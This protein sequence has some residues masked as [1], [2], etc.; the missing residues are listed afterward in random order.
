MS[1]NS[2]YSAKKLLRALIGAGMAGTSL[3]QLALPVLAQNET[4]AGT[5]I[6]NRATATYEDDG[7][8]N[9]NTN[10]NTVTITIAEVAGITV[11]PVGVNDLNGGSVL[12]GDTLHF[13][14]KVTN[15]GNDPTGF[16][17]PV[18]DNINIV[19]ANFVGTNPVTV[20]SQTIGG[21]TSAPNVSVTANENT[22]NDLAGVGKLTDPDQ[23]FDATTNPATGSFDPGD[24]LVVRVTVTVQT[25]PTDETAPIRVTYG[26]TG[27]NNNT[28]GTQNQL[29]GGATNLNEVRTVDNT[30]TPL[31]AGEISGTPVNGERQ[32]SAFQETNLGTEIAPEALLT[33]KKRHVTISAG[34]TTSPTDD[35]ITYRLDATVENTSPSGSVKPANLTG[36]NINLDG[37]ANTTRILISD[38]I[39]ENTE[40]DNDFTPMPPTGWI[41]V[42]TT[43]PLTTNA[44]DATWRSD[45]FPV[46]D[47]RAKAITRVGW[48][49]NGTLDAGTTTESTA[50]GFQFRVITTGI[51]A[52]GGNVSNL[53]QGFGSTDTDGDGTPDDFIDADGDGIPD[54][55]VYDESG[56]DNPN[57]ISDNGTLPKG[58]D[59][60][61]DAGGGFNPNEDD[62]VADPDADGLDN[63]NDNS[64]EDTDP[65]VGGGEVNTT[66]IA[67]GQALADSDILNG[68]AGQPGAVNNTDDDDFQNKAIPF[69]DGD[70][71]AVTFTNTIQNNTS[72]A[73]NN[74]DLNNIVLLPL[75]P[76]VAD[77][78]NPEEEDFGENGDIP[79]GTT[80]TITFDPDQDG[81]DSGNDIVGV[82]TYD[83]ANDEWDLVP[84]SSSNLDDGA[85]N[86]PG[87]ADDF[88]NIGTLTPLGG[89]VNYTVAVDLPDNDDGTE[90]VAE[91]VGVPVPI[92][93]FTNNN[94]AADFDPAT[95]TINNVTVNRVYLG[96]LTCL[97]DARILNANGTELVSFTAAATN[98]D[99]QALPGA[100]NPDIV[101]GN[102]IEYRVVCTNSSQASVGANNGVLNANNVTITEDGTIDVT[103]DTFLNISGNNWALNNADADTTSTTA[104]TLAD[105][106]TDIDT[107]HVM[108]GATTSVG[109]IVYDPANAAKGESR[110]PAGVLADDVA[111]YEV[112]AGNLAPGESVT[113]TFQR[114][115]R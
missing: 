105:V 13:D 112:D 42:Y 89:T 115:I 36:T 51:P 43:S 6:T 80:V 74:E 31:P 110:S 40:Y 77:A 5:V 86:T 38:A 107:I 7:G 35:L 91:G 101:P 30:S 16:F 19:G 81:T 70:P 78:L 96:F 60:N 54:N 114:E 106:N 20:I 65:D 99:N 62:G 75:A 39:P 9:F 95:D 90:D 113:F 53:A 34:A 23:P 52:A 32:A 108:G 12:T 21:T 97:K 3:F 14:F 84:G 27:A 103:D 98:V 25:D 72:N 79:A 66:P 46:D 37:T 100:G 49:H 58:P 18:Q 85:D 2:K 17:L 73:S 102:I 48:A 55:L 71:A 87:N 61:P 94:D 22:T 50:D 67:P 64:G 92:V 1:E 56:D 69:T 83:G 93:A 26:N 68:P 15:T 47:V 33:V 41:V 57:N 88:I 45:P 28:A 44:L 63:D 24:S 76:S 11:E 10:S 82:Y 104:I 111:V 4:A 109:T 29:S 8:Q 59:G